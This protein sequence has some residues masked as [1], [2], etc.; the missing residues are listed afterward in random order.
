MTLVVVY[1][2][3]CCDIIRHNK[4]TDDYRAVLHLSLINNEFITL[5]IIQITLFSQSHYLIFVVFTIA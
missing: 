5:N 2:I 1:L 4:L 3:K